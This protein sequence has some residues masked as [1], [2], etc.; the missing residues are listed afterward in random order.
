MAMP[1]E[2]AMGAPCVTGTRARKRSKN[3]GTQPRTKLPGAGVVL[4]G[5]ILPF[6]SL[7]LMMDGRAKK[8]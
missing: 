7:R 1:E 6:V 4:G 5:N 3:E 8:I 2:A